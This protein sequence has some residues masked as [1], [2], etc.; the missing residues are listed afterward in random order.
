MA[1]TR[2]YIIKI[3]WNNVKGTRNLIPVTDSFLN[4]VHVTQRHALLN[5]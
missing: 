4:K 3:A 1:N 5:T 2:T